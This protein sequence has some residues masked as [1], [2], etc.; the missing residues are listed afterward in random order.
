MDLN[1]GRK[2]PQA[3]LGHRYAVSKHVHD[4]Q[5]NVPS[6]VHKSSISDEL[7]LDPFANKFEI[8]PFFLYSSRLPL[9]WS[10]G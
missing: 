6:L 4:G 1:L 9:Q 10:Y 5:M 8:H 2:P 7:N 3:M